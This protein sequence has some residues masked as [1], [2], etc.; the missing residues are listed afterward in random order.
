MKN[1]AIIGGGSWG[2]A[3]AIVLAPRFPRVTL[4]VYEADLGARMATTRINDIYLPDCSIPT[5]VEI[6][7]VLASA[8]D[9]AQVV[10]GVM[11]SHLARGLYQ[12]M[13]PG[14][15]Q[16]TVF[17]SAT[18]GLENNTLLRTTEVIREVVGTSRVAVIS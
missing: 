17:V 5:N 6:T 7:S 2:T 9:G 10:L 14:L 3:L 12:R 16:S 4:W 11:P 8:L 13:L 18:K 15:N 1:L